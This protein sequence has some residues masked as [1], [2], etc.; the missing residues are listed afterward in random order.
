MLLRFISPKKLYFAYTFVSHIEGNKYV[1][2]YI[3]SL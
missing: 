1:L 2:S 3:M